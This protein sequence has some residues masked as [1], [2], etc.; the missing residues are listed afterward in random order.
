MKFDTL[1]RDHN[2]P[3]FTVVGV[4]ILLILGIVVSSIKYLIHHSHIVH[5]IL[6]VTVSLLGFLTV[7]WLVGHL[8][9]NSDQYSR[10]G[11]SYKYRYFF[12]EW[13]HKRRCL[14]YILNNK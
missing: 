10:C 7:S 5:E 6:L 1:R 13:W 11:C 12:T 9:C 4:F 2:D 3:P 8:I 14:S